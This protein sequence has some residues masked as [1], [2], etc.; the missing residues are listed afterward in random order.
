MILEGRWGRGQRPAVAR[1]GW[2]AE[3][4]PLWRWLSALIQELMANLVTRWPPAPLSR[5][6]SSLSMITDVA[7]PH[8]CVLYFG[9]GVSRG[10][11]RFRSNPPSLPGRASITHMKGV[12]LMKEEGRGARDLSYNR[13]GCRTTEIKMNVISLHGVV[14]PSFLE[15][16][17]VE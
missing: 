6:C 14:F 4:S 15:A 12:G 13:N 7:H 17:S 8:N 10:G 3:L 16:L 2:D 11:W 9:S 5:C 1:N